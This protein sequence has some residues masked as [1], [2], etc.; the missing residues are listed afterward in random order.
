MRLLFSVLLCLLT[1]SGLGLSATAQASGGLSFQS[2]GLFSSS[3]RFLPVDEAFQFSS[4]SEPGVLKLH[5]KVTDGHYLYEHRIQVTTTQPDVELGEFRFS[6]TST[7]MEDPYF[8]AVQV[9]YEDVTLEVPVLTTGGAQEVE[10]Q[11]TYQGCAEAGLCYPPETK[12]ALYLADAA[13]GSLAGESATASASSPPSR[14]TSVNVTSAQSLASHISQSALWQTLG[15][16]FFLGLGL[17]F[18]PCVF[19]MIPI[20]SSIIAGQKQASTGSSF[21]LSLAY[22]LGVATL[23]ALLGLAVGYFGAGVNL[24]A[25]LQEPWLLAVFAA[26]FVALALSMFG[27]YEIQLPSFLRDRLASMQQK[28][29]GG[30]LGGVFAMGFVS[31]LV[32][33]PCVSAPLAGVLVYIAS[34]GDAAL[35]ALILFVLSLGMGVPLLLIGTGA[36][37]FLPRAG[38]WM[39]AI[40]AVFGVLLLAVAIW[41]LERFLAGPVT[42]VLWAALAGISGVYLGAFEPAPRLW[43]R[44]WK[45]TGLLLFVYAVL[46]LIGAVTGGANPMQP[47]DRLS[48]NASGQNSARELEFTTVYN[49]EQL[50]QQVRLAK[51]SGRAVMVD[52]YADWCI[53]CKIMERDTFPHPDARKHLQEMHLVKV[54]VTAN[55]A[56]HQAFL[57][58]FGLFGPP[59]ILFYDRTGQ[60]L[61]DWRIYGEISTRD[62]IRHLESLPL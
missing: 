41:L 61:T 48:F 36:G 45:G 58:Y 5:W 38:A 42:L 4:S 15:L 60:E 13:R 18:T 27:F 39:V 57:S 34:T 59:G 6:R 12:P 30:T 47:L 25:Y 46:L 20:L 29:S 40:K 43:Q 24:Q 23:Y 19:P 10:F 2:S 1:A 26:L 56:E 22:V 3:N 11:V 16:F 55:N 62:F 33:S 52:V 54:D 51:Q 14:D 37:R 21:R 9:F 8:G 17:A 44:L 31:A 35:G 53:S 32:V 49:L 28:Q 50:E 7:P